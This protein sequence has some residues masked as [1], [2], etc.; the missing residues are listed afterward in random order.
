MSLFDWALGTSYGSKIEGTKA[1]V[2]KK[3][4]NTCPSNCFDPFHGKAIFDISFTP[5]LSSALTSANR[6]PRYGF[7]KCND[8]CNK[9]GVRKKHVL[10]FTYSVK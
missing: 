1:W 10:D 3:P 8:L 4:E 9:Q 2:S 5:K 6:Q 7:S